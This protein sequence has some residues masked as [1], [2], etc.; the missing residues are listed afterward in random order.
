VWKNKVLPAEYLLEPQILGMDPDEIWEDTGKV[1]VKNVYFD[2]TPHSFIKG[3]ITEDG[4]I[5]PAAVLGIITQ[6]EVSK[7]LIDKLS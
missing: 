7:K 6:A 5:D 3:Y 2:I 4:I 1:T